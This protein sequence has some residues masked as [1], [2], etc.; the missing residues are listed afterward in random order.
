M[1][2]KG[3]SVLEKLRDVK[4]ITELWNGLG[5]MGPEDRPV[6]TP[7]PGQGQLSLAQVTQ[8]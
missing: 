3:Q 2:V 5:W 4:Q 6:P 8:N 1:C 7:C